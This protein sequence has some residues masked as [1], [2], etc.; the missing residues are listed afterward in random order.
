MSPRHLLTIVLFVVIL[1]AVPSVHA[2]PDAPAGLR[3]E[4]GMDYVDLSWQTVDNASYYLVY[5]STDAGNMVNI[6]NVTAPITAFHDGELEDGNSFI[7]Y[8]TAVDDDGESVPGSSIA[9]TVPSKQSND[10][11]IPVIAMIL[12]IIAIQV[13]AVMLLYL[14]K[15]KMRLQ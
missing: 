9:T 14:F 12:S 13:C 8:V 4:V 5:R 11:L 6:A 1:L 7:Y 2:T 15:S 3:S 10:V